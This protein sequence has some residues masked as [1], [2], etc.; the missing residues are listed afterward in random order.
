MAHL[1]QWDPETGW[2]ARGLPGA[3]S[4]AGEFCEHGGQWALIGAAGSAVCVNGESLALG[5]RALVD[6]DEIRCGESREYFSAETLPL[7]ASMPAG[8]R[9][10]RCPRC[11]QVIV[12]GSLAVR[13]PNPQCGAWH[14]QSDELPC[15]TYTPACSLCP[16]PTPLDG[17]YRWT[18]E[19]Q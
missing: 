19:A 6:R 17:G 12:P 7:V 2:Q 1:W 4:A 16:Q 9:P 3:V 8:A 11:K 18:P 5:L 13:C 10:L 14:H 15:W